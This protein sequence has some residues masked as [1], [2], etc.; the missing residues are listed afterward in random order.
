[1]A[2]KV[3]HQPEFVG[4]QSFFAFLDFIR[5]PER[6]EAEAQRLE[7]LRKQVNKLVEGK[8]ALDK[9]GESVALAETDRTQAK[10]E[11]ASASA[12]AQQVTRQAEAAA[13]E[14]IADAEQR[15]T[16]LVEEAQAEATQLLEEE[17]SSLAEAV[18][19]EAAAAAALKAAEER[20]AEAA[21]RIAAAETAE[22]HATAVREK[23]EER[24]AALQGALQAAE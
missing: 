17:R 13:Q 1:M 11:L 8:I 12:R 10:Q 9:I 14:R 18:A 22:A 19:R 4:A 21:R 7:D 5:D 23:F 3:H 16:R 20:E 2:T 6:V 24:Y 15:A